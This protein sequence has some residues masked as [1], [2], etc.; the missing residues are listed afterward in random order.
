MFCLSLQFLFYPL[1]ASFLFYFETLLPRVSTCLPFPL[2]FFPPFLISRPR[3]DCVHLSPTTLSIFSV[4]L[5]LS[6]VSLSCSYT[7]S[8]PCKSG[9]T[10]SWAWV[11]VLSLRFLVD[12][13]CLFELLP[14][15]ECS[16]FPLLILFFPL[17]SHLLFVLSTDR[18][19]GDLK[20]FHA[21]VFL[22]CFCK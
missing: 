20:F 17:C 21:R 3:P 15:F 8:P 5:P 13:W 10:V 7:E 6:C 4:R 1:L 2:H 18:V 12:T 19:F 11:F 16:F 14:L 9:H 22:L